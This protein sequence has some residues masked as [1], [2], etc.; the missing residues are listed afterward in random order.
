ML[1]ESLG[2]RLDRSS[3]CAIASAPQGYGPLL[4]Q[5]LKPPGSVPR[6]ISGGLLALKP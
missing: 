3:A 6:D 1:T 2:N 5:V 4:G